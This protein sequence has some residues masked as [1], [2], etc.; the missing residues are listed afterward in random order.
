[1]KVQ[2]HFFVTILLPMLFVFK[3]CFLVF[4]IEFL[5]PV[6]CNTEACPVLGVRMILNFLCASTYVT[7]QG[8]WQVVRINGFLM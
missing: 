8:S 7:S 5:D 4:V 1:M 6:Y 2:R 3:K